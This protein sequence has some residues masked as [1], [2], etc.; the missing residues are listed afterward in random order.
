M[1]VLLQQYL[2]LLVPGLWGY[3]INW[4][5]S[6][7]FQAIGLSDIPTYFAMVIAILHYPFN[8][9]YIYIL[10][11]GYIGAALATSTS[12]IVCPIM[13]I[14]YMFCTKSGRRRLPLSTRLPTTLADS[15]IQ[16]VSSIPGILQYLSLAF[17][18]IVIISE[19]WASEVAVFLAGTLRPGPSFG[20]S[21]QQFYCEH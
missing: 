3:S 13:M 2:R 8:L 21:S 6:A 14:S 12:Q 9:F 18:G 16:S 20:K 7:W 1:I 11:L 10:D 15:I 4:T 17:P 19:W 5:L